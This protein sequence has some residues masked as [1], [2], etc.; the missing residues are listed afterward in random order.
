MAVVLNGGAVAVTAEEEAAVRALAALARRSELPAMLLGP[1][2]QQ[3]EL[4]PSVRRLLGRLV[5]ELADGH[6]VSITTH[7]AD[8]T[9]QEAADLLNVSR[10]FLVKLLE[11]GKIPFYRVGNRRRVRLSDAL[12]YRERRNRAREAVLTE[13]ARESQELGLYE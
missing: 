1:D 6:A 12:A 8:L 4:P 3:L 13:L 11:V 10:P 9:T 2:E 5:V 7:R